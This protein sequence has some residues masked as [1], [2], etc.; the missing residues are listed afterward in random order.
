MQ[1]VQQ[2]ACSPALPLRCLGVP[3]SA[4]GPE[5]GLDSQ[6]MIALMLVLDPT[7][8]MSCLGIGTGKEDIF[9]EMPSVHQI[10]TN[11]PGADSLEM[12]PTLPSG[13]RLPRTQACIQSLWAFR[14]MP[15]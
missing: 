6:E 15:G 10:L 12:V 13:I 9:S 7:T 2:V 3:K 14:V 11:S 5:E 1:L 8:H 4:S